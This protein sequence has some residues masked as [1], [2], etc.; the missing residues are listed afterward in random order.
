MNIKSIRIPGVSALALCAG[1][2]ALA[3]P[4][5]AIDPIKI[6]V[7]AA[8]SPGAEW[9]SQQRREG[10]QIALK[11]VNDAGGALGRPMELVFADAPG[12]PDAAGA[13]VEKLITQDKVAAVLGGAD[14]AAALAS[15][16]VAHRHKVPYIAGAR[17]RAIAAKL[18]PEVYNPGIS[19]SQIAAAI[20]EAM[21]ALGVKRVVAFTENTDPGVELANLLAHQL[22]SNELAIQ[23]SFET[24]DPAAKD[25]ASALQP[26]KANPPDAI[27][28]LMRSPAAYGLIDQLHQQGLAPSAKT[29]LYDGAALMEDPAFWQNISEAARGMLVLSGYHPKTTLPEFGRKVADAY[30]ANANK[31]PTT[32]V[33]EAADS[34]LVVAEAIK[35]GGSSEPEAIAK[36]LESLKWTGTRG[37]ITFSAEKNDD[38]YHQWLDAPAV[39][40][41]ITAVKQ[42]L[43]DTNLIQTPGQPFDAARV[44]KPK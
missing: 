17:S 7:I 1:L 25:F 10:L 27:I 23:Y 2:F 15:V 36:A 39:T 31:D 41:Q 22:N 32:V 19:N 5:N 12:A 43:G 30:G 16:E 29:W 44:E 34:L 3:Y 6:G 42:A 40:F 8:P 38:K 20:A 18:Y 24:L 4:A 9:Q 37:K 14:S 13:V 28:Q 35:S 11:I 26:H 21:K 33:F